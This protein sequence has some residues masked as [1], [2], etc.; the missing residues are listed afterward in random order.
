MKVFKM[1]NTWTQLGISV[2][3][4]EICLDSHWDSFNFVGLN[5]REH[6]SHMLSIWHE[7]LGEQIVSAFKKIFTQERDFQSVLAK[8]AIF[9]YDAMC[10]LVSTKQPANPRCRPNLTQ[11]EKVGFITQIVVTLVWGNLCGPHPL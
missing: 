3:Y 4:Y 7:C 8:Q 5:K 6:S 11:Q 2:Q 10:A 1:S 9:K